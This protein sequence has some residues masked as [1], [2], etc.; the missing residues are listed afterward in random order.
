MNVA[1][2][3]GKL[4]WSKLSSIQKAER[5]L[6][7]EVLR[8]VRKGS[9]FRAASKEVGL[10]KAT[11]RAHLGKTIH[12]RKGRLVASKVDSIQRSM[13]IYKKGKGRV[14]IIVRN[15][16]DASKI[17]EYFAAVR[18]AL[19]GDSSALRKFKRRSIIDAKGKKHRFETNLERI[20]DIEESIEEPEFR[21]IYEEVAL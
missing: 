13:E 4:S 7:L 2:N 16:R 8:L 5:K 19:E 9:S 18:R 10:S 20:S 11:I 1:R 15:S 14:F 21:E 6:A 3:L 17:G 12:K